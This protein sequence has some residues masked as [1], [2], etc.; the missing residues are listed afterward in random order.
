ML[1]AFI[2]SIQV[3]TLF[4]CIHS[5]KRDRIRNI[6]TYL[7]RNLLL[8]DRLPE[9]NIESCR[10][11]QSKF[12]EE[13]VCLFFQVLIYTDYDHLEKNGFIRRVE[14]GAEKAVIAALRRCQERGIPTSV[15]MVVCRESV[16][17]IREAVNLMASLGV[18]SMKVGNATP[19]R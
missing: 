5:G 1:S 4:G 16:G 17:S 9:E 12:R 6:F 3:F 2:G 18:R 10:Q 14:D 19:C 7:E 15:S 13:G 11:I 8:T